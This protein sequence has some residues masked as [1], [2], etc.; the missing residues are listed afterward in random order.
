MGSPAKMKKHYDTPRRPWDKDK[1]EEDKNTIKAYGLRRKQEMYRIETAVRQ[2]RRRARKLFAERDPEK[3]S[4]ILKKM[5]D[6]GLTEKDATLE[7]VLSLNMNELLERRLQTIVR[8]KELANSLK[9]AR[10]FIT[11]GH[12]MVGGRKVT[13]PSHLVSRDAEDSVAF[14]IKSTLTTNFKYADKKEIKPKEMPVEK[15]KELKAEAKTE[16]PKEEKKDDA[17]VE[18]QPKE[19]VKDEKPEASEKS[20]PEAPVEKEVADIPAVVKE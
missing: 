14:V 4:V 3:E 5:Y 15:A 13:S 2:I 6:M 17:A 19:E 18:K 9:Q 8:K 12:I 20:V 1:L 10:Q 7:K 11:H 16:H